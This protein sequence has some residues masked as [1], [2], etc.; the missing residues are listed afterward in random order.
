[1]GLTAAQRR[2]LSRK[3]ADNSLEV[4]HL[5]KVAELGDSADAPFLRALKGEHGW[6]DTGREG[7]TRVV[8]FGRWVDTVCRFLEDGYPGL[9]QAAEE[10]PDAADYCV[11]VLEELKTAASV[12]AILD[13]GGPVI[14]QPRADVKLAVRLADGFNFLLSFK[15]V[16]AITPAV[17]QKVR[18]FLHRLLAAEL[19]EVQRASVVCALRGVGDAESVALVASLPPFQSSWAGLEQSA[20]RQIKQRL[21]RAKGGR[22]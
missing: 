12:S 6:S 10:S 17:E 1:M 20:V 3:A 22:G 15:G 9:V 18:G 2:T 14:E 13:V 7:R 4:E 11:S 5:V 19:S 21:R 16:P 8:P